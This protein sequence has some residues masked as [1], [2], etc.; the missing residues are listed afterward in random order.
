MLTRTAFALFAAVGLSAC[1]GGL[2]FTD[3][4]DLTLD[5]FPFAPFGTEDQLH[6]PYVQGATV[7]VYV[8]RWRGDRPL[9]GAWVQ[10]ADEGVFQVLDWGFIDDGETLRVEGRATGPGETDLLVYESDGELWD[11]ATVEVGFPTRSELHASGPMFVDLDGTTESPKVLLDGTATFQ[12]RYFDGDERLWGN[13]TLSIVADPALDAETDRTFLFEN[14][15]WVRVTPEAVG[16]HEI[17]LYV[18]GVLL[19]TASFE[20]VDASTVDDVRIFGRDESGAHDEDWLVLLAQSLDEDGE[21]IYGV[22]YSWEINGVLQFGEGDLY[23]Y[24]FDRDRESTV[25]AEYD[26]HVAEVTANVGEGY[27]DSSNNIGCNGVG[28][29]P[30]G[31]GALLLALPAV[32]RRRRC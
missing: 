24:Q 20:V 12:V 25:V 28:S 16:T 6:T 19:E 13:E 29:L 32:L 4:V 26:G 11:V 18:D 10:S 27:V 3:D 7:T 9:T 15:E 22:E 31:I 2:K 23:R 30:G 14:R 17:D 8:R 1:G 21:R 5:F